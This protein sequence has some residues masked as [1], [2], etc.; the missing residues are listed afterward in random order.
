MQKNPYKKL[1]KMLISTALSS[2]EFQGE[3]NRAVV[4]I[5]E[6]ARVAENEAT[7]ESIFEI[8]IYGLLRE[9][10]Y[11]FYPK[12]ELY[13]T[14]KLHVGRGRTDSRIGTVV[15]EY[16]HFTKLTKN[17]SIED[18]KKQLT[19]YITAISEELDNETIGYIT[20][21]LSIFEIRALHGDVISESGRQD[22]NYRTLNGFIHDVV[23]L[24]QSA[25]TPGNLINDFCSSIEDGILFG[26]ARTLY[27][28]LSNGATKKTKMLR[29]EW[30]E[31]F[32][33]V[34]N[35]QQEKTQQRRIEERRLELSRIFNVDILD[36]STE[37]QALFALHTA[38]AIVLKMIAY[39]TISD[40][41]FGSPLQEYKPLIDSDSHV[42]R[43]FCTSLEKGDLFRSLGI[44]NLLEGDFFSW[45]CDE[46][47]WDDSIVDGIQKVLIILG[48]Y[49][50]VASIFSEGNVIDLFKDLYEATI[51]RVVRGSFG[52]FFTPMWL[53][54]H[55]LSC[56]DLNGNWTVLDPCCGS[57]TFIISAISKMREEYNGLKNQELLERIL[58]R[59]NGIDLNPLSVLM[60]RINVF[61]NISDLL[62]ENTKELVIPIYLGD[63]TYL[64]E[65]IS[66]SG[67]ECLKYEL[68]T[69]EQPISVIL[70]LSL[71]KSTP[72]FIR[73]MSRYEDYIEQEN[74]DLAFQLIIDVLTEFGEKNEISNCV[75]DLTNQL[76]DL[77]KRKWNGIWARI[78]TN[79]FISA[80]LEKVTNIVGNPPWIDWKNL[81]EGYKDKVK[82]ICIDKGLFSGA[83]R[84]GGIN[85]NICALIT[86]VAIMNWLTSDGRLAFL[87]PKELAYQASYE[88]W[89]MS[90]GGTERNILEFYDWSK[91]GH[92]F[93]PVK[94]DFMTFIIGRIHEDT[95]SNSIP[96]DSYLIKR[97][98]KLKAR[99]WTSI[100]EAMENLELKIG[101][102]GRIIPDST[103]Y[104]F[105]NN[106][107]NLE[108][109]SNIA[110]E[111]S[112]IG[113]EGIEFYP[114]ELLLFQFDRVGPNRDSVFLKNI[115]S[116]RS[117]YK[118]PQQTVLLET[119][120]L[121]PLI[122]GRYI[123]PFSYTN[124]EVI[125][126]F[127]YNPDDPHRPIK[128]EQLRNESKLLCEFY[129][130]YEEVLRAQTGFSDKIRG[131]DPGEFYG[132]ARTGPYSFQDVY[133]TFRD[134]TKWCA[135][136]VGT[137][138]LPW[139]E[140]KRFLF[141]N[142]AVSICERK[143][144]GIINVEEAHFIC[145]IFNTPIV[146]EF[147]YA[148]SDDRSYKIRP[149][150]FIPLYEKENEVHKRLSDNS[151]KAHSRGEPTDDILK[152]IE[153]D[154]LS[155]CY[156]N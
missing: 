102:A 122:K 63:S 95:I 89:R 91:A 79:L 106:A 82:N 62:S 113:R 123:S 75:R 97:R 94:E 48:R 2:D 93:D 126:P 53:A 35:Q 33:L 29:I 134:N 125:V 128:R 71:V 149:P 69:L 23:A 118:I 64:P 144:G 88:G 114:Q 59:V 13:V 57:G 104:T 80:S 83:G 56:S 110:G 41:R 22:L 135:T 30:E 1:K 28:M 103:A 90:V 152:E 156:E 9:I 15:I 105:A 101:V 58:S 37:Y 73:L 20:D 153:E 11:K 5:R 38:Y 44:L 147:I 142:H 70:P 98:A 39:R 51:P 66:I 43:S 77:E 25:L 109:Y 130:K 54:R 60:S 117:K 21:G 146:R 81:P 137:K 132:L 150:I 100:N 34:H 86:H 151:V 78:I 145:A 84:T 26:L 32:R 72:D 52:E 141:Q 55:V 140:T 87:M 10:G 12:K 3:L 68:R 136:V 116:P 14:T 127:P 74:S 46:N 129:D 47:Q 27:K 49:E 154:Y 112:Y 139:G 45:Y 138:E 18:A 120:Y 50:D 155:I 108:K 67:I 6:Q 31:L 143:D 131:E 111:C 107:E 65:R 17:K 99:D 119:K 16:K 7:I 133:V 61:I 148:T 96:V 115:Q 76:I 36:A 19:E 40:I 42:L 4:E 24:E 92:P 121:F 124:K 85:L 8:V